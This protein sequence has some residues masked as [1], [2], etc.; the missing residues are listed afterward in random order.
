[1]FT[2]IVEGRGTV[3]EVSTSGDVTRVVV[4]V[5]NAEGLQRGAS[6][7]IDGACLTAVDIDGRRVGFDVIP[8]TIARTILTEVRA[9]A[10]V[11]VERAL[12]FG[13]EVGGHLVSGHVMGVGMI[14]EVND[15]DGGRNLRIAC[16]ANVLRYIHEKGYIAVSGISLTVGRRE[17]DGFWLHLIPE[18]LERTTL[19]TAT[20]GGLVNLE[21]DPLTM[22]AVDTVERLLAERG[23]A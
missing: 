3:L 15:L 23:E 10:E 14:A 17:V 7:S 5:P 8:E 16:Q 19:G 12:R 22:A 1:M 4:D 20:T 2:G 9:G 11:N 18:T 6:V 13:D 21:V